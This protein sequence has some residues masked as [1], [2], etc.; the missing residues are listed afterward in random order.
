[1]FC[2]KCGAVLAD[3]ARK[4][5]RCGAPVRI[6]PNQA[7]K[8]AKSGKAVSSL[9]DEA[10]IPSGEAVEKGLEQ[11]SFMDPV[12]FEE[13]GGNVDVDAIIKI[14]RGEDPAGEE[15]SDEAKKNM[16]GSR[17]GNAA[18]A[19]K[20]EK[21]ESPKKPEKAEKAERADNPKRPE[22]AEKADNPKKAEKAKR[23][24][25]AEKPG[26]PLEDKDFF[27]VDDESA[28]SETGIAAMEESQAEAP[29]L[30]MDSYLSSLP[31]IEKIRRKIQA[32][33]HEREEAADEQR[34]KKHLEKASKH[35]L[36][37]ESEKQKREE[38]RLQAERRKEE[39]ARAEKAEAE[40]VRAQ[41]E[42]AARQQEEKARGQMAEAERAGEQLAEAARQ[43]DEKVSAAAA[44]AV[45]SAAVLQEQ[46]PGAGKA[47]TEPVE[48]QD[49]QGAEIIR[50]Q[51]EDA[52]RRQEQAHAER[53]AAAARLK[54]RARAGASRRQAAGRQEET[55][56]RQE[57]EGL[58]VIRLQGRERPAYAAHEEETDRNAEEIRRQEENTA[59]QAALQ[60]EKARIAAQRAQAQR[61]I[62][63][64][65]QEEKTR[66]QKILNSGTPEPDSYASL[67]NR[68]LK[69][70]SP[71]ERKIEELRR[72]RKYQNNQPD[73]FDE[74]LGK[75]G[76]T[77]EV[78][79]RIATLFLI[80]LLS[81]IYVLGRGSSNTAAPAPDYAGEGMTGAAAGEQPDDGTV[82]EPS[83]D[84]GET[85]VP[86]GG[87]DFENN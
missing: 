75:Y 20:S 34:M 36:D 7:G 39:K 25:K 59:Q 29:E 6:R 2:A 83:Q 27:A 51:E 18:K 10:V 8:K 35:F 87:G 40:R 37:D 47:E 16:K 48:K 78:A 82:T 45:T 21:A 12:F 65:Q 84:A 5:D 74:Y 68:N 52:R 64:S 63:A 55:A 43:Q 67:V 30:T 80:V 69:E 32:R 81:V 22:K 77:K 49:G 86:T 4:C 15:H 85:E 11:E 38:L 26:K 23:A 72:R 3:D 24:E 42:E 17:A 76:L 60:A 28:E 9:P 19:E 1:M 79:V 62:A 44:A 33:H 57:R 13:A 71:E 66:L 73:R 70:L 14:A 50:L 46:A 58:E 56:D 54:E 61:A 53:I 41:R 31:L